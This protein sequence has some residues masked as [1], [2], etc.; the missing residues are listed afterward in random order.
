MQT[1]EQLR[2]QQEIEMNQLLRK[3]RVADLMPVPPKMIQLTSSS[4]MP[5]WVMYE[6]NGFEEAVALFEQFVIVPFLRQESLLRPREYLPGVLE[7]SGPFSVRLDA[8]FSADDRYGT[9]VKLGWFTRVN[10]EVFDIHVT[11]NGPDYIGR[12]NGLAPAYRRNGRTSR[13][14]VEKFFGNSELAKHMPRSVTWSNSHAPSSWHATHMHPLTEREN[15]EQ[16]GA[17]HTG[18][19]DMLMA[20]NADALKAGGQ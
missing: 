2:V 14:K 5:D 20:L 12:W 15:I 7:Q 8:E 18:T 1:V 13:S 19:I 9:Q 6:V 3:H 11:V 4:T 17:D 16:L 10:D